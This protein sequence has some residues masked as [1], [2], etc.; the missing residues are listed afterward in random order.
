LVSLPTSSAVVLIV[1]VDVLDR[2]SLASRHA[3]RATPTSETPHFVTS[4]T[5]LP[6][7]LPAPVN[8]Y[9]MSDVE[10]NGTIHQVPPPGAGTGVGP[11]SLGANPL[12]QQYYQGGV[13]GLRKI[14]NPAPL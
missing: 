8:V 11:Y 10:K 1:T 9:T 13:P 12:Q 3:L 4:A 14:A 2:I 6:P 5:T 7:H